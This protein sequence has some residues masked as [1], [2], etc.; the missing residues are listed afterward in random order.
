MKNAAP[1]PGGEPDEWAVKQACALVP[2]DVCRDPLHN[3]DA[4]RLQVSRAL[5]SLAQRIQ[6]EERE[7]CAVEVEKWTGLHPTKI[8]I[9]AHK[10]RS[11]ATPPTEGKDE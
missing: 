3:L 11:H 1:R 2:D 9:L 8:Y 5:V 7:A 4:V 10:I 6:R